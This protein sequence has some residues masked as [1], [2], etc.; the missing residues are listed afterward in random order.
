MLKI[1]NHQGFRI[2]IIYLKKNKVTNIILEGVH[3]GIKQIFFKEIIAICKYKPLTRGL[4]KADVASMPCPQARFVKN[5]LNILSLKAWKFFK[6]DNRR[7]AIVIHDNRFNIIPFRNRIKAP[8]QKLRQVLVRNNDGVIIH[9][10][11]SKVDLLGSNLSNIFISSFFNFSKFIF[12][13]ESFK[14]TIGSR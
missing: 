12:G 7:I 1:C 5:D 2:L 8:L 4:Q 9:G 6:I 3:L 11:I 13:S 10:Q 14:Q